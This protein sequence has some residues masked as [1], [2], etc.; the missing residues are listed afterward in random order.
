MH[1]VEQTLREDR[2]QGRKKE[3]FFLRPVAVILAFVETKG[4]RYD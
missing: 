3:E 1:K 2:E 4:A